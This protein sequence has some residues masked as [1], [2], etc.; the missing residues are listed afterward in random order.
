MG[1]GSLLGSTVEPT[2]PVKKKGTCLGARETVCCDDALKTGQRVAIMMATTAEI[3]R[4][5]F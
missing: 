2:E 4:I 5:V 1:A 3:K